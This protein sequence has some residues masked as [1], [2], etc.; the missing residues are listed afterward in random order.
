MSVYSLQQVQSAVGTVDP[1]ESVT[2]LKKMIDSMTDALTAQIDDSKKATVDSISNLGSGV[3]E[4][5]FETVSNLNAR[6]IVQTTN[7]VV[8][9]TTD[10]LAGIMKSD[11]SDDKKSSASTPKAAG[12]VLATH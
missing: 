7:D 1:K 4:R 8:R 6:D 10:S 9:K 3:V 2:K 12:E 5:T 11:K